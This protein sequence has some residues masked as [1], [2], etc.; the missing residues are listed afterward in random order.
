MEARAA[1]TQ[2]THVM[3]TG[4]AADVVEQHDNAVPM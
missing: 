1:H 3:I 4:P 2:H